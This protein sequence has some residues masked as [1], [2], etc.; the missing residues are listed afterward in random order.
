MA[1]SISNDL[2]LAKN[3]LHRAEALVWLLEVTLK[4][5]TTTTLRY[6]FYDRDLDYDADDGDGEQTYVAIAGSIQD[7]S[8][9]EG[10]LTEVSISLSNVD[11]VPQGLLERDELL[12]QRLTV[13]LV[14]TGS[15]TIAGHDQPL[16]FI[17]IDATASPQ[18]IT[19]KVGSLHLMQHIF[20]KDRFLPDRCRHVFKD[21]R[22]GY[23]GAETTCDKAYATTG[24]CAGRD[25]QE[26]YGGF[27][28]MLRHNDPLLG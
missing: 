10:T 15:L 22:C 1:E 20:P 25:N 18:N 4:Q 3:A 11:R 7:I 27:P 5:T 19:F 21:S 8:Q 2:T 6:C 24:G 28:H 17:I 9:D 26:R 16:Q 23:V 12:G 14:D 13:R